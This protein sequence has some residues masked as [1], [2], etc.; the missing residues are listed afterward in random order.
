MEKLLCGVDIGGTK[1]AIALVNTK[2]KIIDKINTC[3]HV[4]LK[5]DGLVKLVAQQIKE[6][7]Q[8]NQLQETD[9]VGI[10]M[11]CAGHIRF[12]D[13][14]II[15]TSNLKGFKNYPLRDAMQKYFKIP[16]ILDNDANA[17]AFGAYKFGAGKG[18][19]DMVFLTISTGIGA[20][21]VI[22]KK[23]FRGATG[24][25]GEVGHTIVEPHTELT[26]TCGNKGCLMALACGM[27]LPFLYH[28]KIKE[29]KK[30][31]LN[32][33]P[34]FDISK[35]SGQ[36]LKKGLDMDD[37]VSKEII[38]D[39]AYYVGLGIYNIFQ[40]LNPPLIVLGG[41]LT[42]WG[43]FYLH[44][45]KATFYELARDMIFDPIKIVISNIGADAGVIGAAA[46]TLE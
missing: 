24:T 28:K 31:K 3:A 39:S 8:R 26:C 34:H 22:N 18:Y 7:I 44:K 9:L 36:Y 1:C 38:S 45:I 23:L 46:L 4:N 40:T 19:D 15:T 41:G 33:P 5:E 43:D 30:S 10:G 6:L 37:P 12:R 20:G 27:A 29:G 25:A 21:I 16:V 14:V 11:G 35:L 42:N 13:G 17:Q 32:I 2:G